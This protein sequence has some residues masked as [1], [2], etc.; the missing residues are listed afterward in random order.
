ML[1]HGV[2]VI[3]APQTAQRLV[4]EHAV[5][6][7]PGGGCVVALAQELGEQDRV[8]ADRP[9]GDGDLVAVQRP[10]ALLAVALGWRVGDGVGVRALERRVLG[11]VVGLVL[12]CVSP[13]AK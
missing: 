3:L 8:G 1:C 13:R 4:S 7:Q 9:G 12:G 2:R 10:C 6:A 5:D 11:P